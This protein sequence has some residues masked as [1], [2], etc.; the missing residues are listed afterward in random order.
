MKNHILISLLLSSCFFV[1]CTQSSY[2]NTAGGA[3]AGAAIGAG[4]GAVIGSRSGRA[5]PG[6]AIGAGIGALTGALAGSAL[7][8]Q[9]DSNR[10]LEAHVAKNQAL[11][12]EN[13][14][15]IDELRKKGADVYG[16][17]R[18]VVVNLPDILFAFDRYELTHPAKI[19]IAEISQ[20][21]KEVPHRGIMVEGH[22]DSI[23]TVVYNKQLSQ[24]RAQVVASELKGK[25][26]DG[27]LLTVRGLGEGYPVATNNSEVGRSRNRR[28]EIIIEN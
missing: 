5:G 24:K 1:S 26:V 18:G 12:E 9:A 6:V 23:G 25:G 2:T 17:D 13:R 7:D 10:E 11:L 28:V 21:L 16:T 15:L 19:T 27:K 20:V 22:T 8:R 4:S 14:R 3:L